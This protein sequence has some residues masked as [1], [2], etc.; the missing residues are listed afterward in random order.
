MNLK[1]LSPLNPL[2]Y[3]RLIWWL[4]VMPQYLKAYRETFGDEKR[5]AK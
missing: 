3:L 4:L 2:D 5:L 1:K